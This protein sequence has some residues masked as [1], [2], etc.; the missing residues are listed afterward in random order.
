MLMPESMTGLDLA[1]RLSKEKNSLRV[2]IATGYP[3]ETAGATPL[4]AGRE[5]TF[6]AKPFNSLELARAVRRCLDNA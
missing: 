2:I 5:I 3:V 6:I 4:L 1:E